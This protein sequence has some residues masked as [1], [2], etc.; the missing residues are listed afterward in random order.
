M[1]FVQKQHEREEGALVLPDHLRPLLTLMAEVGFPSQS[2]L[3][4]LCQARA[5]TKFRLYQKICLGQ[6]PLTGRISHH[7]WYFIIEVNFQGGQ[8]SRLT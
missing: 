8:K 2:S 1:F 7:Q 5:P 4:H 3:I 6:D